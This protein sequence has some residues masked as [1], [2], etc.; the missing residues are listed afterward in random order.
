[1]SRRRKLG[2]ATCV[3]RLWVLCPVKTRR[4][5]AE[6]SLDHV[7]HVVIPP[8]PAE[9]TTFVHK[10]ETVRT[11]TSRIFETS[12]EIS[13]GYQQSNM[14]ASRLGHRNRSTN[15]DCRRMNRTDLYRYC[16]YNTT[17]CARGC[18]IGMTRRYMDNGS[19]HKTC[20]NITVDRHNA[21]ALRLISE[22]QSFLQS[23]RQIH[24]D[25]KMNSPVEFVNRKYT[26]QF[27]ARK[28]FGV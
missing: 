28:K 15:D 18:H 9:L 11:H 20:P 13:N 8:D 2:L 16:G 5:A 19:I 6:K 4:S 10:T 23:M 24:Y 21:E 27:P 26:N 3:N 22:V 7:P 1:M 25:R 14:Q 12:S 17:N